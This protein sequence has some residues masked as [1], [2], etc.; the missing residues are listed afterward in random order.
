M[1]RLW[2][3]GIT[4]KTAD[5]EEVGKFHV[6]DTQWHERLG[7]LKR[8]TGAEELCY[9]S[10]CNRVEFFIV[11]HQQ[12]DSDYLEDFVRSFNPSWS[13]EEIRHYA[14][15]LETHQGEHAM[16]HLLSVASSIDSMV[17]G[18]REIITQVRLREVQGVGAHRRFPSYNIPQDH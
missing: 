14:G 5:I 2:S 11:A 17:I 6:A 8:K 15:L 1:N 3:I 9:L 18:E 12:I 10:T 7:A 16:H 13:D 4:H